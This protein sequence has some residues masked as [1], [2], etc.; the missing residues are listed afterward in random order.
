MIPSRDHTGVPLHFRSS[1]TSGSA[2]LMRVRSRESVSPRQSPSSLI[3]ASINSDGDPGFCGALFF[4]TSLSH[5]SSVLARTPR[6]RTLLVSETDEWKWIC[7]YLM[8]RPFTF[9]LLA[10]TAL[11]VLAGVPAGGATTKAE[12]PVVIQPFATFEHLG[13]A[14]MAVRPP[15]PTSAFPTPLA[16]A[17]GSAGDALGKATNPSC[18]P[19]PLQRC[20]AWISR[21]TT[22][23]GVSSTTATAAGTSP[24][25]LVVYETG[26]AASLQYP[27][28]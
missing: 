13:P 20:A 26:Y 19:V 10:L 22:H 21:F 17:S 2:C 9:G 18:Q 23:L 8:N 15:E 7:R 24:D 27:G 14:A 6:A 25:G 1:T 12:A 28:L 5:H 4:T 11:G 3:L 16:A